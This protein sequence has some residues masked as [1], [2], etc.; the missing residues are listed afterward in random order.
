MAYSSGFESYWRSKEPQSRY[1]NPSIVYLL[2]MIRL[3]RIACLSYECI[4]T[5][6]N[7]IIK[8]GEGQGPLWIFGGNFQKK[9]FQTCKNK[10]AKFSAWSPRFCSNFYSIYWGFSRV[11]I[12]IDSNSF[13]YIPY[14]TIYLLVLSMLPWL[15]VFSILGKYS[16]TSRPT[17]VGW[18]SGSWVG[19]LSPSSW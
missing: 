15:L 13:P 10:W 7:T 8:F 5:N 11:R 2:I 14:P 16:M 12:L 6:I 4:T 19:A 3:K 1:A 18:W 9:I 17:R